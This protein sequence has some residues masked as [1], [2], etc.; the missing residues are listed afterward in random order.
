MLGDCQR[1]QGVEGV[2]PD[3]VGPPKPELKEN[4]YLDSCG[5]DNEI[6]VIPTDISEYKWRMI[7]EHKA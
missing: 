2:S 5:V 7:S 4:D 6:V 1:N 3:S